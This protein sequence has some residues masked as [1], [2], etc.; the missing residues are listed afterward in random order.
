[1]KTI[2]DLRGSVDIKIHGDINEPE[3]P[4][5]CLESESRD[6]IIFY[7]IYLLSSFSK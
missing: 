5:I 7:M 6:F 4:S 2:K 1:M 3:L